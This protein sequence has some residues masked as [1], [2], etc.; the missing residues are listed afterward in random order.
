MTEETIHTVRTKNL[1]FTENSINMKYIIFSLYAIAIVMNQCIFIRLLNLGAVMMLQSLLM[2]LEWYRIGWTYC[3]SCKPFHWDFGDVSLSF[4]RV[5]KNTN[6]ILGKA[7]H[8]VQPVSSIHKSDGLGP[9]GGSLFHPCFPIPVRFTEP[10]ECR[11]NPEWNWE[12]AGA[13]ECGKQ[14]KEWAKRHLESLQ[15]VEMCLSFN[16]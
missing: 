6:D 4:S 2:L 10:A 5:V 1:A 16:S 14:K 7:L 15:N 11:P 12:S 13:L 3:K 8:A 9:S